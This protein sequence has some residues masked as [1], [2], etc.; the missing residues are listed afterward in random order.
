LSKINDIEQI[1]E[2]IISVMNDEKIKDNVKV[3]SFDFNA[4]S[5]VQDKKVYIERTKNLF[6]KTFDNDFSKK[7]IA[8]FMILKEKVEKRGKI[9]K[10]IIFIF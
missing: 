9:T 3:V 4:T 7:V 1:N 5:E 8:Y 10:N 2:N 6:Y